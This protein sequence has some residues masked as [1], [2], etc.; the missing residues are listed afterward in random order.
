MRGRSRKGR[1]EGSSSTKLEE[2]ARSA[3]GGSGMGTPAM[4]VLFLP[5]HP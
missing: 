4:T 3:I 1:D 5:F 2:R